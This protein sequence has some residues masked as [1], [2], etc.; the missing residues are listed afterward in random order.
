MWE[1]FTDLN[2]PLVFFLMVRVRL[3]VLVHIMNC[4]HYGKVDIFFA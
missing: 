3:D 2:L 1:L 4:Y